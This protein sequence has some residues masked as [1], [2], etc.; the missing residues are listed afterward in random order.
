MVLNHNNSSIQCSVAAWAQQ[1]HHKYSVLD[2]PRILIITGVW[3]KFLHK[4]RTYVNMLRNE[5]VEKKKGSHQKE[6]QKHT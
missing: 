6:K 3:G 4:E 2:E 5:R 1:I